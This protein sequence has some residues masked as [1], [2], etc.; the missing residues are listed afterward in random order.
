MLHGNAGCSP[1]PDQR[2]VFG[3]CGA[4]QLVVKGRPDRAIAGFAASAS[5]MAD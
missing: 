3:L 2:H 1:R 4:R 5:Q